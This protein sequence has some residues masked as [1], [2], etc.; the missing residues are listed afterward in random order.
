M[1]AVVVGEA[2]Y[3]FD[4]M[5]TMQLPARSDDEA[6]QANRYSFLRGNVVV[7]IASPDYFLQQNGNRLLW[8]GSFERNPQEFLDIARA[9]D[10]DLVGLDA[11]RAGPPVK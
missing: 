8:M 5:M 11:H 7:E 9:I 10:Q 1:A 2:A 6:S 3:W 4:P